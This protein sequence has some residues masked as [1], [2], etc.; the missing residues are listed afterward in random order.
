MASQVEDLVNKVK[1]RG[2]DP[3]I[4]GPAAPDAVAMIEK[5][6][7]RSLPP[8]YVS[9][10]LSHGSISID[11]N[12]VSGIVDSNNIDDGR[13]AVLCDTIVLRS[14]GGLPDGFLVVGPHE[15]GGYCI[16]LDRRR[17]DGECPVVNFEMG[18]IQHKEPVADTFEDWLIRFFLKPYSEHDP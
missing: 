16:D 18:S 10:L 1:A 15:V 12:S 3:W 5:I 17:A 2:H 14:E 13:G 9:F 8:S 4:S 7:G 11:D 6:I